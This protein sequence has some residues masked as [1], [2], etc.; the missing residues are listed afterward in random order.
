MNGGQT[1]QAL[2]ELSGMP[3]EVTR[4]ASL[5]TSKL[6]KIIHDADKRGWTMNAACMKQF[7]NLVT[8]HAYTLLGATTITTSSGQTV[9]LI[10]MRNPWG[11][12]KYTGP[13]SKDDR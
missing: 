11:S 1:E 5:S 13:W 7:D 3:A 12:E 8:G 9:D 4:T 10:Q 2:R 6:F